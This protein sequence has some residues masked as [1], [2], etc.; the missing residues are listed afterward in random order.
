[1][2]RDFSIIEEIKV[3]LSENLNHLNLDVM[4]VFENVENDEFML[5]VITLSIYKAIKEELFK[6]GVNDSKVDYKINQL[7]SYISDKLFNL[8]NTL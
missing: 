5:D 2:E 3:E 8:S 4:K 6:K 7:N 1:M